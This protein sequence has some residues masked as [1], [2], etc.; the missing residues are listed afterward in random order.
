MITRSS[1]ADKGVSLLL[2][3]L[4]FGGGEGVEKKRREK[5]VTVPRGGGPGK[6]KTARGGRRGD[7]AASA[8]PLAARRVAGTMG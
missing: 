2:W 8:G 1:A 5:C 7:E 6:S 4:R 3:Y